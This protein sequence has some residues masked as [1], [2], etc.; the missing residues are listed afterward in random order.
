MNP[1]TLGIEI[2]RRFLVKSILRPEVLAEYPSDQIEQGY[3][4][5]VA[6]KMMRVR[7]KN[8]DYASFSIKRGTGVRR[9]EYE[10]DS[11]H[12]AMGLAALEGCSSRLS[13]TRYKINDWEL[14]IFKGPLKGLILLEREL[15]SEGEVLPSFPDFLEMGQE[16]TDSINNQALAEMSTLLAKGTDFTNLLAIITQSGHKLP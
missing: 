5:A 10:I 15:S 3:I 16:V 1:E 9:T 8:D 12:L 11:V 13:K 2:E 4:G 7:I 6:D 14:D